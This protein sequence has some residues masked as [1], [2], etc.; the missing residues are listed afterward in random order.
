MRQPCLGA[1]SESPVGLHF[2]SNPFH[3]V[4]EMECFRK[5][6]SG[7]LHRDRASL[8]ARGDDRKASLGQDAR[9][10]IYCGVDEDAQEDAG[11]GEARINA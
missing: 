7:I 4:S 6:V 1:S 9:A 11:D 5:S 2:T 3:L 10:Y 8:K